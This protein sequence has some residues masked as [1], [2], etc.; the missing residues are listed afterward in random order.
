MN[1]EEQYRTTLEALTHDRVG[2]PDLG[3]AIA[4]GRRRRRVR[5]TAWAGAGVAVAAVATIAAGSL[6][7]GSSS[8]VDPGPSSTT[9]YTDFVA[10]TAI[11]EH[12]QATV[13]GHLPDLGA[14]TDVYPSD[15]N[16][17]GPMPRGQ[18]ANA[19]DWQAVY[20]LGPDQRLTVLMAKEIPGEGSTVR[21]R[22]DDRQGGTGQPECVT[23]VRSHGA[24]VSDS[25]RL[26]LSEGVFYTFTTTLT[27][28]DGSQ[29]ST[30]D[31]VRA[32]SW[33]AAVQRQAFTSDQ[34]RALVTDPALDFP[35]PVH[36]PPPPDQS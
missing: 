6:G 34:L 7:H 27:R 31:R 1:I 29:V 8:A 32:P 24:V 16:T 2:G 11:D 22:P 23:Y 10:G 19:T 18:F 30:L 33:A 25:Y 4:S 13:A 21:C 9:S 14:A 28:D 20:D 12:F 3:A 17:D 26:E 5:R 36:A 35:D 15:W